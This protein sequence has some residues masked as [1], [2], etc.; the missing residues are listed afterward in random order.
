MNSKVD[1]ESYQPAKLNLTQLVKIKKACDKFMSLDTTVSALAMNIFVSVAMQEGLTN[2][3][4][5]QILG[6][7]KTRI[8]LHFHLLCTHPRSRKDSKGLNLLRQEVDEKDFRLK[9]LYLTSKGKKL[10]EELTELL[11]G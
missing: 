4:L 8:S 11:G 2:M 9:R 5:S 1:R 3:D 6:V 7:T 10:K